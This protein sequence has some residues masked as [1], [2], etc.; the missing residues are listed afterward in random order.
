MN[1]SRCWVHNF[2]QNGDFDVTVRTKNSKKRS[3]PQLS[4][5]F[6]NYLIFARA[7][8]KKHFTNHFLIRN[9]FQELSLY[10]DKFF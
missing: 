9:I 5:R 3:L 8:Y 6:R 1:L 4:Q 7:R 10:T 2:V